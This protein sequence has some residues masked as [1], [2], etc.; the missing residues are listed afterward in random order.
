MRDRLPSV[1]LIC[2]GGQAAPDDRRRSH[3]GRMAPKC[4]RSGGEELHRGLCRR[5]RRRLQ[6]F[7]KAARESGVAPGSHAVLWRVGCLWRKASNDLVADRMRVSLIIVLIMGRERKR[8][9]RIR[10]AT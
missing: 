7:G 5:T 3:A 6:M 9:I 1:Y 4:A 8:A 10:E 2:D